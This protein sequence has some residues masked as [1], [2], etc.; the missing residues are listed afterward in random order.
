MENTTAVAVP[1]DNPFEDVLGDFLKSGGF[2]NI[3]LL[4][5][6]S[7]ACTQ[8]Y[9]AGNFIYTAGQEIED[10]GKEFEC[11]PLALRPKAIDSS[12]DDVIVT[13]DAKSEE[14]K[15]ITEESQS[16]DTDIKDGKMSGVEVLLWLPEVDGGTFCP[17]YLGSK[18]AMYEAARFKKYN[19]TLCNVESKLI[20]GKKYSWF[21][22]AV[23]RSDNVLT[24]PPEEDAVGI[25]VHKFYH[26]EEQ[27]QEQDVP[28]APEQPSRER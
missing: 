24:N 28:P 11:V 3:K 16:K 10:L 14:F 27:D 4:N 20:K 8:G 12:G 13:Y 9:S 19:G 17:Y 25:E 2:C 26:P 6:M 21:A 5:A 7:E 1:T 23:K 15:R 22:P 18:S